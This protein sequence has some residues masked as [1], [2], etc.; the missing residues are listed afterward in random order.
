[1]PTELIGGI[2]WRRTMFI[3]D[4]GRLQLSDL[5]NAGLFLLAIISLLITLRQIARGNRAQQAAVFK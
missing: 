5:V 4:L 2:Q 1:M 3:N